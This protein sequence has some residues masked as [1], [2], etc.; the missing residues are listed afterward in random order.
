MKQRFPVSTYIGVVVVRASGPELVRIR[1]VT[2]ASVTKEAL[3][4]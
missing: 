3:Q 4:K 2:K 1:T